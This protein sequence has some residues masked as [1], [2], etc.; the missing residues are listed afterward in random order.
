MDSE[1]GEIQLDH[2]RLLEPVGAGGSGVVYKAVDTKLD[3]IVAIKLLRGQ[4]VAGDDSAE[5]LKREAKSV[6]GVT[7]PNIVSVIELGQPKDSNSKELL[8]LQQPY[9]VT[10][11]VDGSS[12]ENRLEK[13][14]SLPPTWVAK[15]I[16]DTANGLEAAHQ[17][18]LIHRDIKPSNILIVDKN[19]QP[20]IADFGLAI[21]DQFRSR[22]THEGM[23]AGTPAYMSPEQVGTTDQLD[24]RS[25]IYS[26]GVVLYECLTGEVPFRGVARATIERVLFEQPRDPRVLNPD[27][28]K[29]LS[30]ICLKAISK[31]P[32]RR[33]ESARDFADDLTRWL[34][35]SPVVARPISRRERLGW[36]IK[37][38]RMAAALGVTA[39]VLTLLLLAA[40]AIY[41]LKL[42]AANRETEKA[43]RS[44]QHLTLIA[45]K[46]RDVLLNTV[47]KLV[48][49]VN[50]ILEA[51]DTDNDEIQRRLLKVALGGLES[52]AASSDQNSLTK[53]SADIHLRMGK[54]LF[55]MDEL[56][57]AQHHFD[58]AERLAFDLSESTPREPEFDALMIRSQWWKGNNDYFQDGREASAKKHWAKAM[59]SSRQV[60]VEECSN[61]ELLDD[62]AYG[63]LNFAEHMIE[64]G[65]FDRAIELLAISRSITERLEKLGT[66]LPEEEQTANPFDLAES[67]TVPILGLL[68][69][70]HY[71][72]GDVDGTA[73]YDFES[74]RKMAEFE[75]YDL[76]DFNPEFA[77]SLDVEP[78]E[79]W[80]E[81]TTEEFWEKRLAYFENNAP[82]DE[83]SL[84]EKATCNRMLTQLMI[85]TGEF[86][87]ALEYGKQTVAQLQKLSN[88]PNVTLDTYQLAIISRVRLA[89]LLK[90]N[91]QSFLIP[92]EEAAILRMLD[93]LEN[94]YFEDEEFDVIRWRHRVEYE[95]E[96]VT[97]S[98]VPSLP[99]EIR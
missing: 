85:E 49:Q 24:H 28:P 76:A 10:E 11:F 23:I 50:D 32:L 36:W 14:G 93:E 84:L 73:R 7:H 75:P 86:K 60:N 59:E 98:R 27:V 57:Q 96:N 65:N 21:D 30:S 43:L 12:L 40:S 2:Y 1:S 78:N 94:K 64:A 87:T 35:G 90:A 62:I 79:G 52:V 20:K 70:A 4:L 29:D 13:S 77:Q 53:S 55:R 51:Q 54:V 63:Q 18:N 46:Q 89:Q 42:Q 72:K 39:C 81:M 25:D 15:L 71:L 69:E 17:H 9:L 97:L 31:S 33:Y 91:Q 41:S 58:L 67:L 37:T 6:A 99:S 3:R 22:L 68:A 82:K 38:N 19:D 47:Q 44:E 26:L 48:Y 8:Q 56:K 66:I 16:R 5:R 74:A 92:N 45:G 80:I 95:L 61:V 88:L 83:D 34:E